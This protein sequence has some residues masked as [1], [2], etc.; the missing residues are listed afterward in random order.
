[1]AEDACLVLDG[2]DIPFEGKNG[3][4]SYS[5]RSVL[6]MLTVSDERETKIQR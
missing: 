2:S 6:Q 1:M 5:R 3:R 4:P